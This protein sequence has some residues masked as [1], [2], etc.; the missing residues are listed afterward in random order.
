[1]PA[2]KIIGSG[3]DCLTALLTRCSHVGRVRVGGASTLQKGVW[4]LNLAP[5]AIVGVGHCA[6]Q[7]AASSAC[8]KRS[9]AFHG[10]V[11]RECASPLSN[12]PLRL[13][14]HYS[15]TANFVQ[16]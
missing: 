14:M 6:P 4:A 9:N 13:A 15:F 1:M 5:A 10:A 7:A 8:T 11:T 3:G 2:V 12:L 16:V